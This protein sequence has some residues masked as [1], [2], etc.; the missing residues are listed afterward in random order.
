[1]SAHLAGCC[2]HRGLAPGRHARRPADSPGHR[3]HPGRGRPDRRLV[4]PVHGQ[5]LSLF[6]E[7][8]VRGWRFRPPAGLSLPVAAGP[9]G[10]FF[11]RLEERES[12]IVLTPEHVPIRLTP[13]GLGAR[14][15]AVL[16]DGIIILALC[17][18]VGSLIQ[19][20]TL[21]RGTALL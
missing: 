18:G 17:S 10:S 16:T 11:M 3:G 21:G 7:D 20:L 12:P 6:A 9:G 14:F 15:L 19:A 13:A 1:M 8:R 5:D 2:L 4:L